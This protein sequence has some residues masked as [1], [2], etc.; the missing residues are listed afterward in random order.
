MPRVLITDAEERSVLAACRSLGRRGYAVDVTAS[1]RPA[2]THWSRFCSNRLRTSDPGL[3]SE[4]FVEELSRIVKAG[5][6][7]LLIPGTDVSLLAISQSRERL[8]PYVK[9]G[10]PPHELVKRSLSKVALVDRAAKVGIP[11]PDTLI[12]SQPEAA[13]DAARR[14]GYP[15]MLKSGQAVFDRDGRLSRRGSAL[16][17]DQASLAQLLTEYGRP[18]LIQRV[19]PGTLLSFAGVIAEERLLSCAVSRYRRTWPSEAG[20][21]AFSETIA[22]PSGLDDKV[23]A[24]VNAMGWQG[25]FELE[26]LEVRDAPPATLDLN[27]RVYG[28]LALAERAGAS[29]PVIWCEWLGGHEVVASAARPGYRYRWDDAEIR[30]LAFLIK[31]RRILSAF[32]VLGSGRR[33][34]WAYMSASDP[35]PFMARGMAFVRHRRSAP[36]RGT[37]SRPPLA[38]PAPRRGAWR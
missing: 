3:D 27:P 31:R 30:R 19:V 20:S 33:T 7:D 12:C 10:L 38:S 34:V 8:E 25:I 16:V 23:T 22:T 2:T 32:D 28:S 24:L 18:W 37:R 29:L 11:A 21:V 17:H 9:L 6:Y 26:L 5:E 13:L 36:K 1:Q 14:L 35:L 4:S 15:V